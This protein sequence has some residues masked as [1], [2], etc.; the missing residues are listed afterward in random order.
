MNKILKKY[1]QRN[2]TSVIINFFFALIFTQ[3]LLFF[4]MTDTGK[5]IITRFSNI[6][7]N[8]I[9]SLKVI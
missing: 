9:N 6:A 5:K 4:F 8:Q 2:F 7:S 3:C 1:L